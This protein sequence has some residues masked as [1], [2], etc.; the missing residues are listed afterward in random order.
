M[1]VYSVTV[2]YI[3]TSRQLNVSGFIIWAFQ[4]CWVSGYWES[5]RYLACS[6]TSFKSFHHKTVSN[7]I[8]FQL[9]SSPPPRPSIK[10]IDVVVA[11]HR[12]PSVR[13]SIY[14][15]CSPCRCLLFPYCAL[16]LHTTM[17]D[18]PENF[19]LKRIRAKGNGLIRCDASFSVADENMLGNNELILLE[20][21]RGCRRA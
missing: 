12:S 5:A 13:P 2:E 8:K 11:H 17:H 20:W 16:D 10:C 7:K 14:S 9:A 19:T 21:A 1:I 15:L 3:F 4:G 18:P 6:L